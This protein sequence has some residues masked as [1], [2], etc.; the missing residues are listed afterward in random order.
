MTTIVDHV[1]YNDLPSLAEANIS[2]QAPHIDAIINGPIRDVFLR[3]GDHGLFCLYLQHRHHSVGQDEA[4]VKVEGTAHLMSKQ[5]MDSIISFGNKVVTTTWMTSGDRV[6]PMEYTAVP[7]VTT[8]PS[9]PAAFLAEFISVLASN[10][11]S[12][13]FG[14]DTMAKNAWAEIKVGD[15]SVVVPSNESTSY[16]EDKFIPVAFAFGD[17]DP[18]FK[19][20]GKCGKDH[21]H[22]SKPAHLPHLSLP[23]LIM[24]YKDPWPVMP[25]GTKFDGKQLLGLVRSG[26]SPFDGAWDVNLLIQELEENLGAAVTDIPFVYSGSNNY[27]FHVRLSNHLDVVARL[28]RGDVNMPDYDGFPIQVQIPEVKF[29]AAVYKL[30]DSEPS[31]SCSRLLYYRAPRQH[32]GLRHD[33]PGDILGRR[34]MVFG[35]A[36]GEN[37]VWYDL[38]AEQKAGLLTQS[39][40]IRASLFNFQLP[41]DFAAAWLRDRLFEQKPE[42]LPIPVAPTREFCVALFTAKIEATIRNEG[43]MIGWEDDD[44]TVGPVAAAAKQS[45]LRLIPHMMPADSASLYRLVLDHGDFGIHNMSITIDAGGKPLVTSLYD[46]ETGCIMPAILSDPLMAVSVDLV[47]DENGRPSITRV[48][49]DGNAGERVEYMECATHYFE[50]L[51]KQAPDYKS[52]IRAGKDARHLWFA[53]RDW[54][55]ADPESYFGELGSWAERRM[56]ELGV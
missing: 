15:A 38:T 5:A 10:E 39:A 54:R 11:C 28:A 4:V 33:R 17:D 37:N 8:V 2:R 14:I 16:D 36:E 24:Y 42:S 23:E 55:G 13:V 12:G 44:N 31:I 51:F 40:R 18:K 22:T 20:H 25:D 49:S 30:L 6:L 3:H 53:L 27:G 48:P 1:S 35:R 46:W 26:K 21:K 50:V 34:L 41:L 47:A 45:L 9:P 7:T 56:R 43:D 19:V 29:E 32:A 52:A